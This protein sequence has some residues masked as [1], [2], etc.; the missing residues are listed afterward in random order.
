[1]DKTERAVLVIESSG[2]D[3]WAAMKGAVE[4]LS[5]AHRIIQ[6]SSSYELDKEV[7]EG[8]SQAAGRMF[9]GAILCETSKS[10]RELSEDIAFRMQAYPGVNVFLLGFGE[11]F[12]MTP[13]VT[14]PHPEL[15]EKA[16]WLHVAAELWPEYRHPVFNESL[17]ELSRRFPSKEWGHFHAQGKA[18]I[19]F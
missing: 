1:M 3:S 13:Q 9:V 7:A 17:S 14:I 8:A 11:V 15:H 4:T 12:K 10:P 18:L 5:T 16:H 19:D 2:Q 6:V